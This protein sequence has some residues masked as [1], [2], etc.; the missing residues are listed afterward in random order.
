[1]YIYVYGV[2]RLKLIK[3]FRN[4]SEIQRI[5]EFLAGLNPK[6]DQ[7][8]SQI[9]GKVPLPSLSEVC[10]LVH[11]EESRI[12]G[13][14]KTPYHDNSTLNLAVEN[15]PNTNKAG[16]K[17]TRCCDYC[18][19]PKQKRETCWKLNGRPQQGNK[20]GKFSKPSKSFQVKTVLGLTSCHTPISDLLILK[21]VTRAPKS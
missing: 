1:M 7:L 4:S 2:Y 6:L 16:E 17:D 5:F 11:S 9:L 21:Y 8:R 14:M 3:E 18:K 19:R 13:M 15:N 12:D 10:S 20:N